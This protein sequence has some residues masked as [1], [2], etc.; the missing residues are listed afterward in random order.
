MDDAL[1]IAALVAL[2]AFTI[3]AII[4]MFTIGSVSKL[5]RQAAKSLKDISADINE[6]KSRVFVTL[7]EV[8]DVKEQVSSTL[9]DLSDLKN[10]STKSFEAV[11]ELRGEA[12]LLMKDASE[13]LQE[14]KSTARSIENQM[15]AVSGMIK[16]FSNLSGFVFKKIEPPIRD[17]ANVVGAF[18]KAV[19]VFSHMLFKRKD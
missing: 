2:S 11:A 10:K 4:A 13:T 18:S 14:F 7:D 16:P 9:A 19:S 8:S 5:V 1:R 12:I 6:L 3:L 15:D 17:T